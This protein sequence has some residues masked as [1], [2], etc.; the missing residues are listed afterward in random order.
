ME[1]LQWKQQDFS[2]R[3]YS[4][5]SPEGQLGKLVFKGWSSYSAIFGSGDTSI[6]FSSKGWLE[7]EVTIRYNGEVIGSAV[8]SVFGKTRI[9]MVSGERY[10][11]ESKSFS[12]KQVLSDG[13]GKSIMSFEQSAFGFGKGKVLVADNVPQ[14]TRLLLLSTG[15]YFKAVTD[16]QVA[17]MVAI[18]IPVFMQI[19]R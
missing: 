10:L 13:A 3:K 11:L 19:M 5:A 4:V 8:T 7:Q 17:L 9:E 16:S 2:G 15:L 18:F 6:S 12:Q 14:L 1:V